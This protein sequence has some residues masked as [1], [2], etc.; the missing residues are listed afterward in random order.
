MLYKYASGCNS[1]RNIHLIN[2]RWNDCGSF[3]SHNGKIK[4]STC[5]QD[6]LHSMQKSLSGSLVIVSD[7]RNCRTASGDHIPGTKH[8]IWIFTYYEITMEFLSPN[9]CYSCVYSTEVYT[10]AVWLV[11]KEIYFRHFPGWMEK[12]YYGNAVTWWRLSSCH[13]FWCRSWLFHALSIRRSA[14]CFRFRDLTAKVQTLSFIDYN[15]DGT[16]NCLWMVTAI[17]YMRSLKNLNGILQVAECM[18]QFLQILME[19]EKM[20]VLRC[21]SIISERNKVL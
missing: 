12:V 8:W 11:M 5:W 15:D 16:Q 4:L 3:N 19:I 17:W 6:S 2:A 20:N 13:H 7:S 1:G 18:R 14:L 9:C 21:H 10:V